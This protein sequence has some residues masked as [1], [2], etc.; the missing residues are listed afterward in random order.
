MRWMVGIAPLFDQTSLAPV[1]LAISKAL[2]EIGVEQ[3]HRV[4]VEAVGDLAERHA[5]LVLVGRQLHAIVEHRHFLGEGA[6]AGIAARGALH[7]RGQ[8]GAE[9]IDARIGDAA[10][11][12]IALRRAGNDEG[13]A[14]RAF[15][16][17]RVLVVEIVGEILRRDRSHIGLQST[18]V[19]HRRGG[20][21]EVR[22]QIFAQKPA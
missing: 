7:E 1:A 11:G 22:R 10:E 17:V 18:L 6:D 5:E 16:L 2:V 19:E 14:E 3:G 15:V 9:Q 8:V 13:R 21:S 12:A 4:V 20:G